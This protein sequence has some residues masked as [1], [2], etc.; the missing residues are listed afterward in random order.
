MAGQSEELKHYDKHCDGYREEHGAQNGTVEPGQADV[1]GAQAEVD[2]TQCVQHGFQPNLQLIII[3]KKQILQENKCL[4]VDK[5]ILR[6]Y[7]FLESHTAPSP[8]NDGGF[9]Y[10][11]ARCI[12]C[13]D[14]SAVWAAL[15]RNTK[16]PRKSTKLPNGN[17]RYVRFRSVQSCGQSIFVRRATCLN[18]F[19]LSI[20]WF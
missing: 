12:S 14:R 1:Q 20:L 19:G 2:P 8:E 16:N 5:K 10:S 7:I 17:W 13:A 11:P 6:K 3:K 9:L 4:N 18:L 15:R